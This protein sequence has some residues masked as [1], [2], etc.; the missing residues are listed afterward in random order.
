MDR[1]YCIKSETFFLPKFFG[2]KKNLIKFLITKPPKKLKNKIFKQKGNN[3]NK[4]LLRHNQQKKYF[5]IKN[6][7]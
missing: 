4:L 5:C 7:L 6:A 1:K 3:Q 2:Y